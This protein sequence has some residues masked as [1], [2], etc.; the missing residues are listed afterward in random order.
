MCV[1]IYTSCLINLWLLQVYIWVLPLLP[2]PF[3]AL[4]C[5]ANLYLVFCLLPRYREISY[6]N[7]SLRRERRFARQNPTPLPHLNRSLNIFKYSSR[8][9]LRVTACYVHI[10]VFFIFLSSYVYDVF[11]AQFVRAF[12]PRK[13]LNINY[14]NSKP[15]GHIYIDRCVSF[16]DS[17]ST[18]SSWC[19]TL[20]ISGWLWVINVGAHATHCRVA[21]MTILNILVV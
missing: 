13:T 19:L 5:S 9:M 8:N 12:H 16:W 11:P 3:S 7:N 17:F 2:P 14:I 21:R 1:R 15:C 18:P 20:F 6:R 4:T 10:A